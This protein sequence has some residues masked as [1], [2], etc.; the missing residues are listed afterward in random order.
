[1]SLFLMRLHRHTHPCQMIHPRNSVQHLADRVLSPA[2]S[3]GLP[4]TGPRC[5]LM[6]HLRTG[7]D[8]A[9]SSY[10]TLY[11]HFNLS[12]PLICH[13]HRPFVTAQGLYICAHV[14]I[15]PHKWFL[16]PCSQLQLGCH[17]CKHPG[18]GG[19]ML[20]PV[21][22]CFIFCYCQFAA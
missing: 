16:D 8:D 14:C 6:D 3:P 17:P 7:M 5:I 9:S 19:H 10:R 1:M 18:E 21:A 11:C 2:T 13:P 20:S 15:C 4:F 12:A 22:I